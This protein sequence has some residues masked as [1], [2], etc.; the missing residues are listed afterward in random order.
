M[1]P[2]KSTIKLPHPDRHEV[3]GSSVEQ[4]ATYIRRLIFSGV[5]A[6]GAKVPQDQ[7]ADT[8][9]MTRVP[10]RE[11]LLT[12]QLEGRVR[13]EPNRGAF[14]VAVTEQSA[15]DTMELVSV[16]WRFASEKAI[17]RTTPQVISDLTA[18]NARV[19]KAT[20]LIE[21]HHA[22]DA[23]QETI[24][25][26]GLGTRISPFVARLRHSPDIIYQFDPAFAPKVRRTAKL[27]LAAFIDGDFE[28]MDS[29][30]HHHFEEQ[31]NRVLPLL[32]KQGLIVR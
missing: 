20:D 10:L 26:A 24:V 28:A 27:T 6:P 25:Q 23:F 15:R 31:V 3:A 29:L 11:A 32:M 22:F 5:L 4:A 1:P 7:I 16:I 19:Q 13:I 9:G 18:A 17:A 21:L 2:I 8:L 12:L 14:V 30:I